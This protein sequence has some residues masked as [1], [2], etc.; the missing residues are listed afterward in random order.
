ML[1]EHENNFTNGRT[2]NSF[3]ISYYLFKALLHN[4]VHRF[5]TKNTDLNRSY[6]QSLFV[7]FEN[8]IVLNLAL[9][10]TN[11]IL[12]LIGIYCPNVED[13]NITSKYVTI[14]SPTN[15]LGYCITCTD[16]GLTHLWKCQKLK[17]I[18]MNE[19]RSFAKN[20]ISGITFTGIRNLLLNIPSIEDITYSDLGSVLA[21]EMKNVVSL[22]LR[23][24]R[25]FNP[26]AESV[27]DILRLCKNLNDL[28]MTCFD[29]QS[30][31]EVVDEIIRNSPKL[32]SF[33]TI[34]LP[35]FGKFNQFFEI[36][37][38]NLIELDVYTN[39]EI[40]T[41]KDII[42]L[43]KLCPNLTNLRYYL[44]SDKDKDTIRPVNFG[45]F[46][47]LKNLFIKG[48]RMD[49]ENIL[50]FCLENAKNLEYLEIIEESRPI[51]NLDN[52]LINK[53]ISQ[54][55]KR[56]LIMGYFSTTKNGIIQIIERHKELEHFQITTSDDC[57]D[58]IELYREKYHNF[59]LYTH[60]FKIDGDLFN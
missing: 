41:F 58:I 27:G 57:T 47:K 13:L 48:E 29:V 38:Q 55:V 5:V 60:K 6:W 51:K 11:E 4:G 36:F 45:Q 49:S 26:T 12:E 19:P 46:S 30:T 50:I 43:G 28:I 22:N 25:H 56:F 20:N 44:I 2:A 14:R 1:R 17:K 34:H 10:C 8:L 9:S 23:T 52:I 33:Q 39:A 16:S 24:V 54:I 42:N 35:F 53:I 18:T 15:A 37:G 59:I 7:N 32:K 21:K 3:M 40:I 31:S